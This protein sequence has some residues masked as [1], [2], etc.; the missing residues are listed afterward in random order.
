[1]KKIHK[2]VGLSG[3][4]GSGKDLF[5][6]VL[7]EKTNTFER[8]ALADELKL[9]VRELFIKEYDIDILNCSRE[10][11]DKIR[12]HLVEVAKEKRFASE[13]RH[14][15]NILERKLIPLTSD[16]CI[17]D[18]R[19][20]DYEFDEVFRLRT[21]M[22]VT[23]LHISIY[24]SINEEKGFVQPPNEEEK[25]NDPALKSKADYVIEWPTFE[26][27]IEARKI[28]VAEYVSDFL[29]WLYGNKTNTRQ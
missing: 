25:R 17:T 16:I 12:P 14:W 19:Y 4:A 29:D 28:Q 15:V 13:G 24:N 27:D 6:E 23:L 7:C 21:Q 10:D 22:D 9:G 26:G 11:K 20:D 3:V 5:C 8:Y 2:V 18:V 1:M